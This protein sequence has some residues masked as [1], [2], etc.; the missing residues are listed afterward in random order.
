[1]IFEGYIFSILYVLL[2]LAVAW[3]ASKLGAPK[4]V[5]RKLVHILVGFEWLILYKFMGAASPHFLAVCLLFLL[6]L[7]LDYKLK[8]APVMSSEGDNAPGTVYYALA[9]SVMALVTMLVPNMIYPFGIAVFCTSLGDGLAGL[10]GR[11]VTKHNKKIWNEKTIVGALV[12]LLVSYAVPHVFSLV[13]SFTLSWWQCFLVAVFAV[14]LELF[15]TNGLD[16]IFI[17]LGVALLSYALFYIPI[18][19]YLL[20]IMLTPAV[21]ALCLKKKALTPTAVIAALMLDIA[22]SSTFG[23]VGFLVLMLFFAGS[24]V[25]DKF[26]K[27]HEKTEQNTD[28]HSDKGFRGVSQVFANGFVAML[29]ALLYAVSLERLYFI[30]FVATMAEAFSDTAASGLGSHAKH[31]YDIF[32]FEKCEGG[33]SGGMSLCGTAASVVASFIVAALPFAFGKLSPFEFPIVGLLGFAGAIFDS[34]LGSLLQIKYKCRACG[35][36]VEKPEH[37]NEPAIRYRG[38]RIFTNSTVNFLSTLFSAIL[39]IVIFN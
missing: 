38:F 34:L 37:C 32:R 36:V 15:A 4:H 18:A 28:N 11:S 7:T 31:V 17:T 23:N 1:M 25:T 29:C 16:N 24:I 8:L 21:I 27:R 2:C 3:L 19:E 20:P 9:M 39:A 10:I 5:T 12:N 6:L 14:E 35:S 33:L 26:K 22:I 13:T 30:A